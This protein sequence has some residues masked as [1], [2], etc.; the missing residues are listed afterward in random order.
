MTTQEKK[1]DFRS[2]LNLPQTDFPMRANLFQREPEMMKKWDELR[3]EEKLDQQ[4]AG[5]PKYILHD[6]PPYANGNIHLGHA[7]N[8]I[9]KDLVVR[10][11]TMKGFSS[12]Y[13]PGWDCH[14]LPIEQ[15]VVQDL[16]AK[17]KE[18]AP[19]EI[20]KRCEAYAEKYIGIQREEFKRLGI[21]G[22]WDHPYRTMSPDYEVGILKTLRTLVEKQLVYRGFKPVYWCPIFQTALAEAEIEYNEQHVSPSIHV[23]FPLQKPE[24]IAELKGL[25][26]PSIVIW[27]TTPWTLPANVAVCLHPKFDYVAAVC[28]EE[29]FIVAEGLLETFKKECGLDLCEVKAKFKAAVLEHQPCAHPLLDKSSIVILGDHVTLEQGTGCVHTAPG[30][31]VEDYEIGLKYNLPVVMPVDEAGRF[32][33]DY[34]EMQ[35]VNV[36]EANPKIVDRLKENG[37]LLKVAKIT[38]KYPYSWRSHKPIIIRATE[39]WF[40]AMDRGDVRAKAIRAV[41]EQVAWIPRWGRDRILGML[42]QRPDWCLSRQRAWGV[43]IPAVRCKNCGHASIVLEVMDRFI[44]IVRKEGTSSWFTRADKE[45]IPDGLRC[46][47]CGSADLTKGQDILDVW[48]ESGSSHCAVLENNNDL[49]LPADL[50]LEGSDQHRGW[51]QSSLLTS[52]GTR[53]AAPFR[54]VLTHGFILDGKGEA[55]SKSKG[56]VIAPQEVIKQRGAD[57]LRLWVVSEDYRGDVRVSVEIL[58][59]M[60]EAY[61]RIRNTFR[62]LLSNL[63]DFDPEKNALPPEEMEEFDRWVLHKCAELIQRVEKAYDSF[64]FHKVFHFIH[65]FCVVELSS[66]YLDVVKDRLYVE[67]PNDP[68]RRSAQSALHHL[69]GALTRM[70]APVLPFTAD[71]VWS[72]Y[73]GAQTP[74]IHLSEFPQ[75]PAAWLAPKLVERWDQLLQVRAEVCKA[76]EEDRQAKR[77]GHS[78]DAAVDL[79]CANENLANLLEQ[80]AEAMEEVCIVSELVVR[81]TAPEAAAA[82][83]TSIEGLRVAVRPAPGTKCARCWKFE[84]TV[85]KSNDHESLCARCVEVMRRIGE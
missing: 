77:I 43:P 37:R 72:F 39:Q 7:L 29:T 64:E 36:F 63:Y 12:T 38:H 9:L 4:R 35:G 48:F 8:K 40:M 79:F 42:E 17:V 30:H 74:S 6:G 46:G 82:R 24:G 26:K 75:P 22:R 80:K 41:N 55:M 68:G 13:I 53:D 25:P 81:R 28:G 51:F 85:G 44:E 11:K 83:E 10:Y 56:N 21:G 34:K 14:G 59:R 16:G 47:E 20:R 5:R 60:S 50:Y 65:T 70:I 2:T 45:L 73:R 67:A 58:D 1:N 18:L 33:A 62:F 49:S 54:A 71:E 32:T 66:L 78:L 57:V 61:R 15:K 69:L 52:I 76:L 23:R 31:G 84:T 3:L 19:I 27:T